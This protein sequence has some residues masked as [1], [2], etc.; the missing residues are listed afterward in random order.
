MNYEWSVLFWS[1]PVL[2][3]V[4]WI[5]AS[6]LSV[7]MHFVVDPSLINGCISGG[8]RST[9]I[10]EKHRDQATSLAVGGSTPMALRNSALQALA[11]SIPPLILSAKDHHLIFIDEL[12]IPQVCRSFCL[13]WSLFSVTST[14]VKPINMCW[15]PTPHVSSSHRFGYSPSVYSYLPQRSLPQSKPLSKLSASISLSVAWSPTLRSMQ[16]QQVR[17]KKEKLHFL[18]SVRFRKRELVLT[19]LEKVDL[20]ILAT[21]GGIRIHHRRS[22]LVSGP[23][24]VEELQAMAGLVRSPQGENQQWS[25]WTIWQAPEFRHNLDDC[26]LFMCL[27]YFIIAPLRNWTHEMA[28]NVDG[29]ALFCFKFFS[30]RHNNQNAARHTGNAWLLRSIIWFRGGRRNRWRHQNEVKLLTLKRS[31]N[32]NNN[33]TM[34]KSRSGADELYM[35]VLGS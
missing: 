26:D 13:Q 24:F 29:P 25:H 14:R 27:R 11:D 20:N 3:P 10:W 1:H 18:L 34:I 15:L 7:E 30:H 12:L 2:C 16:R 31:K 33:K 5:T 4:V 19:I 32:L 6:R 23:T 21:L 9:L 8:K 35:F 17:R 28:H 22:H